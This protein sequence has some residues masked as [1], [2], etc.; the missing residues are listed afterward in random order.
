MEE[1]RLRRFELNDPAAF[2]SRLHPNIWKD[3]SFK[4]LLAKAA[5]MNFLAQWVKYFGADDENIS[6]VVK[7]DFAG[8]SDAEL[9]NFSNLQIL[10]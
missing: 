8:F 5:N 7:F 6:D 1:L 9:E 10:F 4:K 2:I 3:P